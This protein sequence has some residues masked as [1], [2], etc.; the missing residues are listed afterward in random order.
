MLRQ[1]LSITGKPGLFKIVSQGVRMLIVE[2]LTSKKRFPV[3]ARDKVVSLGDIAM[4]TTGDD[5]PLNEILDLVY[6]KMKGEKVDV[7]ALVESDGL[8]ETFSE[9]LPGFDQDRVYGSDIKKLFTWYNLLLDAGFTRFSAD[10]KEEGSSDASS[11][12]DEGAGK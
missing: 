11:S 3:H 6:E 4:Y 8:K 2:D 9:I 10:N 5:K 1:I 7:K 12:E